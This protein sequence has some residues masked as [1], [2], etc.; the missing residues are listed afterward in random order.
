MR[1]RSKVV[2]GLAGVSSLAWLWF[3]PLPA[4]ASTYHAL[5][6]TQ[7]EALLLQLANPAPIIPVPAFGTFDN[8]LLADCQ[9]AAAANLVIAEFPQAVITTDEVVTAFDTYGI[10]WISPYWAG[11]W[12]LM[13]VGFDG[14]EASSVTTINE[15]QVEAAANNGGV[16]VELWEQTLDPSVMASHDIDIVS[17]TSTDV[18]VVN[19]WYASVQDY[20]WANWNTMIAPYVIAYSAVTWN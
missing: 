8:N 14:F 7:A 15:D 19:S 17:A 6:S 10:G 12:Y 3:N 2:L 1:T 20:S 13:N 4:G 18:F 9:Y 11:Q 16:E 5:N